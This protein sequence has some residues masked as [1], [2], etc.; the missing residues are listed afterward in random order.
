[1]IRPL[2]TITDIKNV[3]CGAFG[4]MIFSFYNQNFTNKYIE[5]NNKKMEIKFKSELELLKLQYNQE[6]RV[7]SEKIGKDRIKI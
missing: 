2:I 3:L 4:A 7:L 1:M 6:I 5:L